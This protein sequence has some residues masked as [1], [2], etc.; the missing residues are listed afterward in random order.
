MHAAERLSMTAGDGRHHSGTRTKASNWPGE[1]G[2]AGYTVWYMGDLAV[3][4][5]VMDPR[6]HDEYFYMNVPES[7][8][9]CSA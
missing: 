7:R 9:A 8:V 2:G 6:R 4:R 1:F 3:A 5:P